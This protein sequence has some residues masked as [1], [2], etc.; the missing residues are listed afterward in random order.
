LQ[1]LLRIC[2]RGVDAEKASSIQLLA[3]TSALLDGGSMKFAM[4]MM[5]TSA[6]PTASS[7]AIRGAHCGAF[8][9]LAAVGA[10][11]LSSE[12]GSHPHLLLAGELRWLFAFL[13]FASVLTRS[14]WGLRGR[15]QARLRPGFDRRTARGI[16]LL[17][18]FLVGF[19]LLLDLS[20]ATRLHTE[21]CQSYLAYGVISLLLVRGIS[22]AAQ[23]R[24]H[25]L[26]GD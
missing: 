10:F 22:V 19:Q 13:L 3:R 21:H 8:A 11:G 9:L 25:G 15:T 12:S 2:I 20:T 4:H 1:S 16:Y 17:L 24:S 26:P 18:Y 23:R 6:G 7:M 5:Q 14:L